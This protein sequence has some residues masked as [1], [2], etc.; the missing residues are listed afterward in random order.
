MQKSGIPGHALTVVS[1]SGVLLERARGEAAE[2]RPV[3]ADTPFVIGSTSKSFT[4]LAVMQLVD[5]GE[6]DLEA[7]VQRYVPEFEMAEGA[8]AA[9]TVRHLL[10]Q[11]SGIMGTAGGPIMKSAREGTAEEA[12]AELRDVRPAGPPGR[13][14]RYANANFVLAGLVVERASGLPYGSYVQQRIFDPLGMRHSYTSLERAEPDGLADGHRFWFGVPVPSGPTAPQGVQAAGYLISSASD[15]GRYLAMY[16]NGGTTAQGVRIISPDSLRTLLKP[17][18]EA[19]LGPWADGAAARYAMGWFVG[20]PWQEPALL[21][22]GNGPDSSAMIVVLPERGWAVAAV[23]NATHELPGA[24]PVIDRLNRNV[25]DLVLGEE[26]V[27]ANSLGTFYLI[28]NTAASLLLAAAAWG[29]VRAIRRY[30]HRLPSRRPWVTW[31]GVGGELALALVLALLPIAAGYGWAGAWLWL[32]DLTLV[33]ASLIALL[34]ATALV[35]AAAALRRDQMSPL[36]GNE[37]I[38]AGTGKVT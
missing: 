12:I 38:A 10:Q 28:F 14:F 37:G 19:R 22:P 25:V 36:P 7:P 16:L 24:P 29:L 1:T 18:P 4:A 9:I 2:G 23:T 6:V 27:P 21:H 8:A 34:G 5:A 32:P 30:R 11:T 26:P 3:T 31:I 15:L 35:L 13:T 33:I 17:G 20:G